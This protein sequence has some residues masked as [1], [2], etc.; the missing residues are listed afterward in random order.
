MPD[1]TIPPLGQRDPAGDPSQLD[2][3]LGPLQSAVTTDVRPCFA[4]PPGADGAG[5]ECADELVQRFDGQ[6]GAP[7]A[8]HALVEKPWA[9]SDDALGVVSTCGVAVKRALEDLGRT[10]TLDPKTALNV[11]ACGVALSDLEA[12]VEATSKH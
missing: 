4:A 1:M 7:N 12:C 8:D 11:V 5:G 10:G 2:A 6:G 9:C 3:A